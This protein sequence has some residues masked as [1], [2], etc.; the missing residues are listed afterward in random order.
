MT[1]AQI[2]EAARLAA[3]VML[4]L[5]PREQAAALLDEQAIRR[6]NDAADAAEGIKFGQEPW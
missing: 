5:V 2:L 4:A 1:P 3:D 6:A